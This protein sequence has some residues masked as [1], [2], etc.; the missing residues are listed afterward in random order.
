M[1]L[2]VMS[3][4]IYGVVKTRWKDEIVHEGYVEKS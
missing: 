2:K 1:D 3:D 4:R